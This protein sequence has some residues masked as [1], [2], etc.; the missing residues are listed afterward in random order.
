MTKT[1]NAIPSLSASGTN[2]LRDIKPPLDI[3]SG[4]G[5]VWWTVGVLVAAALLFR[6]RP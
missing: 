6:G 1:T 3:P 4:W 2:S 5:L